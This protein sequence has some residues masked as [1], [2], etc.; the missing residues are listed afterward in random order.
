MLNTN[1][2]SEMQ[3]NRTLRLHSIPIKKD[4]FFKVN[5]VGGDM[6]KGNAYSLVGPQAG[7]VMW[8]SM[9]RFLKNLEI[10]GSPYDPALPILAYT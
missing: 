7:A 6:G 8:K 5:N 10:I 1:S 2:F 3:I 4:F 9:W